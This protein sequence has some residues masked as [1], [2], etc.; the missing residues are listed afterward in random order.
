RLVATGGVSPVNVGRRIA[1]R[2]RMIIAED[3]VEIAI[4]VQVSHRGVV[5]AKRRKLDAVRSRKTAGTAIV[6]VGRYL[7]LKGLAVDMVA[8]NEIEVTVVV[9]VGD[10]GVDG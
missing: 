6:N 3:D 10:F 7:V 1:R 8:Q 5:R 9:Q 2:V 4:P